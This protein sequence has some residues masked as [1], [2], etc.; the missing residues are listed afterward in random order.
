MRARPHHL[1]RLPTTLLRAKGV[2]RIA[3]RDDARGVI[4]LVGRRS[5]LDIAPGTPPATSQ[6]VAIS[7]RGALD[8]ETLARLLDGCAVG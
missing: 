4:Q 6:F 1:R 8:G 3:G 5:T 2:L 7:R